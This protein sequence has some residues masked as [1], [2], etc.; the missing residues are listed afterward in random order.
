MRIGSS[1]RVCTLAF[2]V[3]LAAPPGLVRAQQ[4]GT[5]TVAG[6]VIDS[7]TK[8]PLTD[9]QVIVVGTQRGQRTD[10]TG[11]FR[12]ISV[13]G[14]ARQVRVTRIGYASSLKPVNVVAGV[15][16]TVDFSLTATVLSLDQVVVT[17]TGESERKRVTGN[18][19]AI[20]QPSVQQNAVSLD[21]SQV[22]T[23]R[24]PG[25]DVA[26]P[27][28][29]LGSSPRIRIRGASSVS[30]SNDPLIVIDGVRVNSSVG[31]STIGV[32]GQT[33]SRLN[34]INPEDIESYEVLK[35]PAAAALYGTAA[36]NGV[37]Q[38]RTKRG[39][40]GKTIWNGFAEGG[41]INDVT[42]YP[43][44]YG[45]IGTNTPS[46]TRTIA[47]RLDSQAA[48]RCTPTKDS[49]FSYNPLV[50]ESPFIQGRRGTYGLSATGGT[51]VSSYYISGSFDREQGVIYTS[52]DQR[53][54]FRANLNTQLRPNWTLQIGSSYLADHLR[55][56]QDDNNTLGV[57]SSGIL[58]GTIDCSAAT[59]CGTDTSSRGYQNGQTP[60]A[61]YAIETRQDVQRFVNTANSNLQLLPWLSA[62]GTAGLDLTLRHDTQLEP[63]GKINFGS[64]FQGDRNSNPYQIFNY[65]ANGGLSA[66]WHVTENLIATSGT[67][68]QFNKELF[69]GTRAFG[70]NLLGGTSSLSGAASRFA[71]SEDNTDNKTLGAY[72]TE[73]LAY[74]D[75]YFLNAALRTDNNSAFGQNFG[76]IKYPSIS[77]SW[78][79]NDESFFPKQNIVSSLRLR[80][81]YGQSGQRPNFRDA[82]TYFNEQTVTVS[83]TDVPGIVVG[84]T[85]NNNLRPERSAETEF[86]FDAGLFGQHASLEVTH[87]NKRTTDLLIAVPLPGSL[88]LTTTQFQNLGKSANSGWEYQL[89]TNVFDT[90]EAKF[91]FTITAS[92]NKNLLITLGKLPTGDSVPPIIFGR[93]QH[94]S[95]YPLGGYWQRPIKFQDLNGDHMISLVNC[96]NQTVVVGGPACELTV[97]DTNVY[98][99]NPLPTHEFSVNPHLSLFNWFQV[100]AL[101]DHKGGYKLFNNTHRFHCSF[102]TCQ[103][104][105]DPTTSLADQAANLAV[106]LGTDAGY[107]EDASFTKLRELAFTFTASER[108]AHA[109]RTQGLSLVIAGRNLHTWTKY[110]GF[111]P[112]V[113]SSPGANFSTSDFLTLPPDRIWNARIN[114]TW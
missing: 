99:G 24:V 108:I 106:S 57:V 23:G 74:G 87:Y 56:P 16:A 21:V 13:P 70:A 59:P 10:E 12:I 93:Q 40:A 41:M 67:G 66:V 90:R 101:F 52:Q 18:S 3:A 14:G 17:A 38:I 42:D 35:G 48:G 60:Q 91:D 15:S 51:D 39:H 2:I 96:P 29:T 102:H 55:L 45:Q 47:C 88:G 105:F 50:K 22:L 86:G 78:V 46:G 97:G 36:A 26:S 100:S 73:Q 64:R 44:N 4:T 114:I 113:N 37:I 53:S 49:L 6:Q 65:T 25:V 95:G 85:G 54:N 62:V 63:P 68:V 109:F 80:S 111:D 5:G 72:G 94:R 61:L 19:I 77:A 104:A 76:F 27:G 30:L 82:I 11:H 92:T 7:A 31:S 8:R 1:W 81:A 58:G 32:G 34:D 20:V 103:E 84:G 69:R 43:A 112:E 83:G 28:G 98:L 9:V 89:T 71:V 107:I 75:R 110:T 33:P 79:V